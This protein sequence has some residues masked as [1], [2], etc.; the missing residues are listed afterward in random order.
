M[1]TG[2]KI[3]IVSAIV[4]IA[5]GIMVAVSAVGMS[6][7]EV[8]LRNQAT[9]Q[10]DNIALVYDKTWKIIQQKAG[11]ADEY[12]EQFGDVYTHIMSERYSKGDGTLMK[13]IQ[14]DNPTFDSALMVGLSN[15]IGGLRT[16]FAHEQKK[17]LDI[18]RVH[19]DVRMTFPSSIICG[20]RPEIKVKLITSGK[21]KDTVRTGE[22]NDVNLFQK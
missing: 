9:A 5:L 7:S 20:A 3:G 14:E 13:W 18:K 6:N 12:K 21:T 19:D 11:V 17:L 1:S 4:V 8:R 2:S 16:E 15:S 10:Q 22:E